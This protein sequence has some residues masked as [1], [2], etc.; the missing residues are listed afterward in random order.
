MIAVEKDVKESVHVTLISQN[1]RMI[2]TNADD[3]F[4]IPLHTVFILTI[5]G[6][7]RTKH[8]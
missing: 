2:S 5:P 3:S 8:I 7:S 4:E 6:S 1:G